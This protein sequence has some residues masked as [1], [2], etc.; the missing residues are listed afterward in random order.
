LRNCQIE[1][2]RPCVVV[3][4]TKDKYRDVVVSAISSVVPKELNENEILLEADSI[5]NLRVTSIIKV[6]R[7]VTL[8]KAD[9]FARIGELR[10]GHLNDFITK[11]KNLVKSR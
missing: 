1:N 5:N 2:V 3:C 9:I 6:D 4:E 10:E 7:I 8:K 11:F